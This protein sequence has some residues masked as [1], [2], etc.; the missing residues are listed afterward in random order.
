M[1]KQLRVTGFALL[2]QVEIDFG[3][4][5]N[6]MTGETG[7]GKSILIDAL[8]MILGSRA[9]AED[10]RTGSD[11]AIIEALFFL[12]DNIEVQKVLSQNG[13]DWE[14]DGSLLITREISINGKNVSRVNGRIVTLSVLRQLGKLLIDLHGQHQHQSLL[15]EENHAEFLD[16]FGGE[17]L[18]ELKN[19]VKQLYD[20]I[21]K[22]K[23]DLF[24]MESDEQEKTKLIELLNYQIAE[25]AEA[26]LETGEEEQLKKERSILVNAEKIYD[27]TNRSYR[28]L[29]GK[30]QS[31]NISILDF[32]F[33]LVKNLQELANLDEGKKEIHAITETAFFQLED[34]SSSLRNYLEE[35]EFNPE[36]IEQIESRLHLINQLK[37]K[38]GGTVEEI[39][40][41]YANSLK[42][43]AEIESI[44]FQIKAI[45]NK[46]NN[47]LESYAITAKRLSD[48]RTEYAEQFSSIVT[49]Q[50]RQLGMEN[51]EFKCQVE[52][53]NLDDGRNLDD[54]LKKI[55]PKGLDKI[56]F[57]FSS[58]PG[59]PIKSLSKIASG[60]EIS[61][62]M[63]ALK[64]TLASSSYIP[65][66]IFDEIDVG[67]GGRTAYTIGDK[68]AELT[69]SNQVICI[70]HLPQ[71]ACMADDH[72]YIYKETEK[73]RTYTKI[74]L[75]EEDKRVEELSRMLGR[76]ENTEK[77]SRE[78]ARELR[79]IAQKKKKTV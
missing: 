77:I 8:G 75:L 12:D 66:M 28:L 79:L 48:L 52:T 60:G 32:I 19:K 78:H 69:Q 11:K 43:L 24:K 72:Y 7:A 29:K 58:N 37:R 23:N 33:E 35:I 16:R 47:F 49:A 59:E 14:E 31:F 63:L 62:L 42:K 1:L 5:L 26:N 22:L 21:I 57:L 38:Y 67:V 56:E 3:S 36:R 39:L 4:G 46:L 18:I 70:T 74:E 71:I 9:S 53:K 30:E 6:I 64:V 15:F 65:T 45:K 54:R 34:I 17:D 10:V 20:D 50:I 44:E 76:N 13:V 27:L 25:I 40:I 73:N 41:F 55:T 51:A 61:R 68:L 2:D